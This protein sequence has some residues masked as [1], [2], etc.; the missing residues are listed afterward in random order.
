VVVASGGNLH[1]Q[2]AV[3]VGQEVDMVDLDVFPL[4]KLELRC[5]G[6]SSSE[7]FLCCSSFW[8]RVGKEMELSNAGP[9]D[10]EESWD[11]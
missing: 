8:P 6:P 5:W 2:G 7:V 11:R 9:A 4:I 3:E 1:V 10:L